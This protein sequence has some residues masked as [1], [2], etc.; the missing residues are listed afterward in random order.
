M[1]T[2]ALLLEHLRQ[3]DV[4]GTAD[5][6]RVEPAQRGPMEGGGRGAAPGG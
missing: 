5:L 4:L 2:L 1:T 3:G 6:A